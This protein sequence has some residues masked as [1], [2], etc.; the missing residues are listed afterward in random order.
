M[1]EEIESDSAQAKKR[2][3]IHWNPDAGR[4]Q[5][6]SRWT[7]L[8]IAAWGVGGFVALLIV[9]GILIRGAKLVFGPDVFRPRGAVV[10]KDETVADA[11]ASFLAQT[12]AEQ[13]RDLATKSLGELK[14]IPP[15]HPRQTDELVRMETEYHGGTHLLG[16]REWAKAL[17]VFEG[18]RGDIDAFSANLKIK[19]EAK[20]SY[21]KILLRIKEL[22]IARSLAPEALDAAFAAA[23]SGNRLVGDGDFT[24]AKK[25]F[26][27]GF[28]ELRKAE[29]AVADFVQKNV[30]SGQRALAR[31]EKDEARKAFSAALE[32]APANEHAVQGL[33]RSENIDRVYA[34]LQ[35][36]EK[37]EKEGQFAEAA[38]S[39]KKA[40]GLDAMSAVAQEG[41]ARAARLEK[42]TKFAAAKNAADAAVKARDWSKAIA[43]YQ[44]AL[45]VYPQKPEVQAAL[46]SARESAHKES[47]QKSLARGFSHE[48]AY[49]WREAREA[50]SETLQLE[51]D[52]A[53]A[54]E[55]YTRAGT[56]IRAL[57]NYERFIEA[58]E[59]AAN[60]AEFQTAIKRF[61]EAMAVKPS[62]LV[63]SDRVQQL[64]QLLMSQNQPVDVTF[65][66]DGNTWVSI[67]NFRTPQKI[68]DSLTL[69]MLPGNYEI[70]G[71]RKGYRDVTMLLQVR[72]GTPPPVVTVACSVSNDRS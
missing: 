6:R 51:P 3:I 41:A 66:S 49:Q 5:A 21:N 61:N 55:G 27:A 32:K 71:R 36:G 8:R 25:V 58:A 54:K 18:L 16:E 13:L 30:V 45:K 52:L 29:Q 20:Q 57:L 63:A 14:R 46:K 48:K 7:P 35:Q 43:E 33:K 11:N 12:K 19:G 15:D 22:E 39:Y 37:Q 38:E 47:V 42:E 31:G 50:Y 44:A 28:A 40:F 72:N 65:K 34:L 17:K 64:Q 59:Q 56:V 4:E 53:D 23:A 26:D 67:T 69:K 2:R 70:I 60:K 62:Y 9:A 24:G 10:A 68:A 1:A